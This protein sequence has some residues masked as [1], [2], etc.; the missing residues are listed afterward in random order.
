MGSTQLVEFDDPNP[1]DFLNAVHL[2]LQ[3]VTAANGGSQSDG[4]DSGGQETER[5]H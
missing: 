1:N 5:P 3:L 2:R 4:C